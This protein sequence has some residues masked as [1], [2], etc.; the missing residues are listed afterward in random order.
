[1]IKLFS[2]YFDKLF[3]KQWI[4]G[5][6]DGDIREIIRNKSFDPDIKWF[7]LDSLDNFVADPFFIKSKDENFKVIFEEYPFKDDYGKI[8]LMTIDKDFREVNQKLILDTGSHLSYPFVYY[9]D[10]R[11][12]IFPEAAKSGKLSCYEYDPVEESLKFVKD[13]IDLPLRDASFLKYG[14]K[15][16]IFGIISDE[17]DYKMYLFH[18]D[19][20]LGPYNEHKKNPVK[21]GL[22]GTRSAGNFIEVDGVIY[23]P[24]QNCINGYGESIIV[25]K[26]IELN[27]ENVSEVPYFTITLNTKN[28]N[29]RA[30]HSLHTINQNDNILVIDG[31]QWT[32]APWTQ[33]KKY[34]RDFRFFKKSAKTDKWN[35]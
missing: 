4:I 34:A 35:F 19:N 26:L 14:D 16:W 10:N 31:E 12:F 28:R 3:F 17:S 1:M 9:E 30:I 5:I 25:N 20:L 27:E 2:K 33:L 24:A 29:N 8:S 7:Y 18:S 23:R 32:F 21:C 11:I 22:N 6:C 13:I 15:Y